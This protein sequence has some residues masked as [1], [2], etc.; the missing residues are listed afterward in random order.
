M[1]RPAFSLDEM[2]TVCRNAQ[3]SPLKMWSNLRL[4]RLLFLRRHGR[5]RNTI[6]SN[7]SS[8]KP[9]S[10]IKPFP[11]GWSTI[12]QPNW[13]ASQAYIRGAG[14]AFSSVESHWPSTATAKNSL[15]TARLRRIFF[16][17]LQSCFLQNASSLY[18]LN[19]KAKNRRRR[20]ISHAALPIT[21]SNSQKLHFFF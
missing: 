8:A 15:R 1:S 14:S 20:G 7:G 12:A 5:E 19:N 17:F 10:L 18:D 9:V 3:I 2:F 16:C 6:V 13:E 21:L 4:N 11:V